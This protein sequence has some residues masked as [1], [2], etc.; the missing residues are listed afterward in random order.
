[1]D[2]VVARGMPEKVILEIPE[3]WLQEW[4][5]DWEEEWL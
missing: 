4:I 1:M 2:V 5:L 3:E